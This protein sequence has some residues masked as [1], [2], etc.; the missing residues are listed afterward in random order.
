MNRLW[1]FCTSQKK[2]GNGTWLYYLQDYRNNM[3]LSSSTLPPCKIQTLNCTAFT[4]TF[5]VKSDSSKFLIKQDFFQF[6]GFIR[7]LLVVQQLLLDPIWFPSCHE[8]IFLQRIL[9]SIFCCSKKR[10]KLCKIDEIKPWFLERLQNTSST[11]VR[12]FVWMTENFCAVFTF[13]FGKR[14]HSTTF[15]EG[16]ANNMYQTHI[17]CTG[18][19]LVL[20]LLCGG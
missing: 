2:E 8:H 6:R 15:L 18:L 12:K 13:C 17:M 16:W 9:I 4:L 20:M 5:L 19:P 14:F 3:F 10:M 1:F 11:S 7:E